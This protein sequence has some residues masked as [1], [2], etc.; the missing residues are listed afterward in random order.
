MY[1]STHLDSILGDSRV[2]LSGL[3]ATVRTGTG[4]G[5]VGL[6][7]GRGCT[8]IEFGHHQYEKYKSH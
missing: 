2:L 8:N 4:F 5:A 3:G 7:A 6:G 1:I